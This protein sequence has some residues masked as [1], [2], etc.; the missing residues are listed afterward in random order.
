MGSIPNPYISTDSSLPWV[1]SSAALREGRG[2]I[3]G[4]DKYHLFV[5][6]LASTPHPDYIP[7]FDTTIIINFPASAFGFSPTQ[8]EDDG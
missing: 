7:H 5:F 2:G 8:R 4:E 3:F 1:L 6:V